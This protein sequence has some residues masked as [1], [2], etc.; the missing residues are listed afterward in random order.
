[1]SNTTTSTSEEFAQPQQ[2]RKLNTESKA[3]I[4]VIDKKQ[5]DFFLKKHN[6]EHFR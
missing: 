3:T 1:M 6:L 5:K 4:L 2:K